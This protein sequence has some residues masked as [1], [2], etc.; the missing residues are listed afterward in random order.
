MPEVKG[1][2]GLDGLTASP[3]VEQLAEVHAALELVAEF[4]VCAG[5]AAGP[6]ATST[7][8]DAASQ[9]THMVLP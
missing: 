6:G 5:V 9:V 1:F 4:S 3:A 2:A 8:H 7:G